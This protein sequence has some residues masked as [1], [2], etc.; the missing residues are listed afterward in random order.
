[1]EANKQRMQ[2]IADN[3]T[4]LRK[5]KGITQ[6][7]LAEAIGLVP[8]TIT[9]YMKLRS[10]P[11]FGI[12]QK[13]ADYF[14]VE[15]SD[16]D[17]TFKEGITI[18]GN[19]NGIANVGDNRFEG[20]VTFGSGIDKNDLHDAV[21]HLSDRE[22][23]EKILDEMS[24]LKASQNRLENAMAMLIENQVNVLA[25]INNVDSSFKELMKKD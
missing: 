6:K 20:N 17:T 11:S 16:I 19:V 5:E 10:A 25:R 24:E 14:G 7:E 22:L 15:K 1:M 21:R 3:I 13:M 18:N 9:D 2:I 12:I 8:G 23:Q 4:R